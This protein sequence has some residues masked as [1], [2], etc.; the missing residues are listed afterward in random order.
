MKVNM[1]TAPTRSEALESITSRWPACTATELVPLENSI[2][3]VT[4]CALFS[5]NTLPVYRVSAFDGYAVR[6]A[7]FAD[8]VPDTTGWTKGNQYVS[9][10]TGDDFPDGYD[11]VI[12]VEDMHVDENGAITFADDFEFVKGDAIRPAG[13]ALKKGDLLADA[14][15]KITG[16]IAAALAMGG[17]RNVPV[18]KKLKIAFIPTGNELV[19]T[20]TTPLRGYNVETNGIMLAGI[21][22]SWGAETIRF[23][24]I[25]DDYDMLE[26]A[27]FQALDIADAV[28][29]NGGS[30]VGGEDFNAT[31][32][33]KHAEF[34]SHGVKAVPGRPVGVAM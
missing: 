5:E 34:F 2:G 1:A 25:R 4:A 29:I 9:A 8:G 31:I 17:V 13:S 33:Q 3:R 11:T 24:I 23:P 12:A 22:G 18:L 32:L 10:D 30:S 21:L 20:G 6:S 28:I 14:H 16:E 27:V 15:T 7:D 26:K 19:P